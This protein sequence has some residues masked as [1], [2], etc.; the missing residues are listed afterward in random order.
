MTELVHPVTRVCRRYADRGR[1]LVVSLLPGDL[2]AVRRKGERTRYLIT[3]WEVY[4][5]AAEMAA[6]SNVR[7]MRSKYPPE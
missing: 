7:L 5:R 6:A 2:V 1:P 4:K 3:V